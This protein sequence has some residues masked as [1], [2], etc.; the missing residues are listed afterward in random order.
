M[1]STMRIIANFL[2][3]YTVSISEN[4]MNGTIDVSPEKPYY[5]AGETITF[6]PHPAYGYQFE[7]WFADGGISGN[8]VPLVFTINRDIELFANFSLVTHE[9]FTSANNGTIIRNPD[10]LE[11][12]P[13]T[14]VQLTATPNEGY[15]FTSWSGSI[16]SIANPLTIYMDSI[17]NITAN[18]DLI[19]SGL[20]LQSEIF[21]NVYPNPSQ[22]FFNVD[23]DK[24]AVYSVYNLT[25]IRLLEG[26]ASGNF[27]LDMNGQA[28]GMYFLKIKTSDGLSV[29][30]ILLN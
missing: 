13:G 9:L 27:K 30:P 14:E 6:T 3:T 29:K 22:V 12:V 8:T 21:F 28:K 23:I 18:F 19:S 4:I 15:Q 25:G 16:N 10:S 2:A 17:M 26:D 11:Y 7:S 1:D 24:R 20:D 5:L